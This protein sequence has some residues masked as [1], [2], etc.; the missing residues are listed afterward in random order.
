MT[1]KTL[2]HLDLSYND[3]L[4]SVSLRRLLQHYSSPKNIDL[5]G[6]DNIM[7]YFQCGDKES[8]SFLNS[9]VKTL[10]I[11]SSNACSKEIEFLTKMWKMKDHSVVTS[12]LKNFI[13][14]CIEE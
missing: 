11:S 13:K 3:N 6:C 9:N 5:Y 10:T 12:E 7:K 2:E 1:T 4:T 8:W 14:L